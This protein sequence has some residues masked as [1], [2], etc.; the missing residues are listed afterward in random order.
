MKTIRDANT[1]CYMV[2]L[3]LLFCFNSARRNAR[4]ACRLIRRGWLV[5]RSLQLSKFPEEFKLLKK[6]VLTE[7][8]LQL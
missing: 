1:P 6:A 7:T 5:R 3:K 2:V 4:T 8:N